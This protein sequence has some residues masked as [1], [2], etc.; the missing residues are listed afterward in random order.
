MEYGVNQKLE[1]PWLQDRQT[2]GK[3]TEH[4]KKGE[5][6]PLAKKIFAGMPVIR[7]QRVE[8]GIFWHLGWP[9]LASPCACSLRSG[10]GRHR[11]GG[12]PIVRPFAVLVVCEEWFAAFHR[13]QCGA[14]L[15]RRR[16]PVCSRLSEEA[17]KERNYDA[18]GKPRS[19]YRSR[20]PDDDRRATQNRE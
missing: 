20:D 14:G 2:G 10:G 18:S 9:I 7:N 6:S 12:V 4:D 16:V 17:Q 8:R 3:K 11:I 1:R 13:V 5:T 15:S 19:F